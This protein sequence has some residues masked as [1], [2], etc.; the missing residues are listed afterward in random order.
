MVVA[1]TANTSHAE[2]TKTVTYLPRFH[3]NQEPAT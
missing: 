3:R 2:K 1:T